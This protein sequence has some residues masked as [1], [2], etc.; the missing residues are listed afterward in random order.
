MIGKITHGCRVGGLIRYLYG[1]G[2]ANE[3]ID[4]RVVAGWREPE[5]LEP[6]IT[7]GG[8]R[9]FRAMIDHLDMP[10]AGR[11]PGVDLARRCV[12]HCALRAAPEDPVLADEQWRDI[13]EEVMDS[14]GLARRGERGGCRW[15]AIRHADDHVHLAVTLARQDGRPASTSWDRRSM[16][17]AMRR[18]EE[19]Y[20]LRLVASPQRTANRETLRG[21]VEKAAR[22]NYRQPARD[23]LR[24]YVETAAAGAGSTAEF[25]ERL[26][27]SGVL[28]EARHSQKFPGELS[29][30]KVALEA[31]RTKDGGPVWYGGGKLAPNLSL[32]QLQAR[33]QPPRAPQAPNQRPGPGEGHH[34]PGGSLGPQQGGS[35]K[36]RLRHEVDRAARR[37][38]SWAEFL[39]ELGEA[40]V[41]VRKRMS[42]RNPG[43]V[44][45]YSVGYGHHV[46]EGGRPIFY[47][48]AKLDAEL[49]LPRLVA[50]WGPAPADP[51][52]TGPPTAEPV[53]EERATG[54]QE[55]GSSAPQGD[56]QAVP[57]APRTSSGA[58]RLS[59]EERRTVWR[60]AQEAATAAT[61]HIRRVMHADPEA[62]ADAARSAADAL[63]ATAKVAEPHGR[64]PLTTAAASYARA[65]REIH[66]RRPAPA[67]GGA[68]LRMASMAVV[69][70][71]SAAG[72]RAALAFLVTALAGLVEAVGELRAVQGRAVQAA[73]ARSTADQLRAE[74][75]RAAP[76]PNGA[77]EPRR[78]APTSTQ[79]ES[80]HLLNVPCAGSS[81]P[82]RDQGRGR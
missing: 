31:Y 82:V 73:A 66:G 39:Q 69:L 62:A 40:N 20:G 56:D 76:P 37:S 22:L 57:A 41:A 42:E 38:S 78:S 30:Y 52:T 74:A 1:P 63:F 35:V 2:K 14:V 26:R 7:R 36:L 59:A 10:L 71:A 9:D 5:D 3:H 28:V 21:E 81:Q 61:E 15:V 49:S 75:A 29:G 27:G 11:Q 70:L 65:A 17:R 54:D 55:K 53:G 50:R 68:E 25:F 47:G 46:D 12:W 33:W 79:G 72:E 23:A 58:F 51:P 16:M 80:A 6:E 13:A 32:P 19:R 77:P 44:T 48:G 34:R 8:R 67:P 24:G 64:G 45:G 43:E 60:E 18:V 4:P